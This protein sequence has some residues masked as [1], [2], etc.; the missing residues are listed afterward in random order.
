MGGGQLKPPQPTPR[1]VPVKVTTSFGKLRELQLNPLTA[2]SAA[3]TD[4]YRK[5]AQTANKVNKN[6]QK[7]SLQIVN[8][9]HCI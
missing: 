7:E 3:A 9:I 5:S 6:I 4:E 1:A 8:L 2:L